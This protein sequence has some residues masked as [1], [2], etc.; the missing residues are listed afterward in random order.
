MAQNAQRRA[1]GLF[2]ARRVKQRGLQGASGHQLQA[3]A[4]PRQAI[5]PDNANAAAQP[6]L[7][8]HLVGGP[9]H[10]VVVGEDEADGRVGAQ[11]GGQLLQ[12]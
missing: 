5:D 4:R 10:R 8:H 7:L 3:I 11:Q 1:N 6:Q 12:H 9:G 2:A